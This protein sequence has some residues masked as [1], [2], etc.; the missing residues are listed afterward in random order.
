MKKIFALLL[1]LAFSLTSSLSATYYSA[2]EECCPVAHTCCHVDYDIFG[3][4]LY[5]QPNGSNLYYGAEAIPFDPNIAVPILSPNWNIL[6]IDPDYHFGFKI[7]ARASFSA[8]DMNLELNWER[9][10]ANDSASLTVPLSTDMVGPF[11]D[12][13]PNSSNYKVAQGKICSEF[14]QVNLISGKQFCFFNNLFTN[15]YGGIGFSRIKQSN[16]SSFSSVD[17]TIARIIDASSTFTGAGPEIGIDYDCGICNDFFFTG[18]STLSLFV[19]DM[20]NHTTY[21]SLTP[22][23]AGFGVAQP[24]VQSTSVPHRTQLVPGFEQKLGVAYLAHC[25][26]FKINFGI[27]Y[28]CQIYVNAVQSVDMTSQVLPAIAT[29]VPDVGVFAVGFTR[30]LS[31]YI[32]SGPYAS[33]SIDF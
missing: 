21:Q 23:L 5:L 16:H 18:S 15:F 12:I 20:K 11:F 3:D 32:L 17:G 24:N 6:E 4:L 13:G 2:N 33:L 29:T 27:G 31:N 9:L 28:Q 22:L 19:G 14:D 26:C 10:H 8:S 1:T 25:G 30:T 7:G